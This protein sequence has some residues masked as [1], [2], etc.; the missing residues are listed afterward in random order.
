M[1]LNFQV[2]SNGKWLNFL[3]HSQPQI[4]SVLEVSLQWKISSVQNYLHV[5]RRRLNSDY[6]K[7]Q[8]KIG[9]VKK[10]MQNGSTFGERSWIRIHMKDPSPGVKK[11]P[12]NASLQ[13]LMG[14][15]KLRIWVLPLKNCTFVIY[16][17]IW[18]LKV[19]YERGD[20]E[21]FFENFKCVRSYPSS[22]LIS[23][24]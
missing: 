24:S 18:L 21:P 19:S 11:R 14:V 4:L 7:N 1:R 17:Q 15:R 23:N 12:K 13:S 5:G 16:E 20:L 22:G 6:V 2:L 3:F 9:K 10:K 8:P